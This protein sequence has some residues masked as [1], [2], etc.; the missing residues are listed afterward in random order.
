VKDFEKALNEYFESS[1]PPIHICHPRGREPKFER[2]NLI[3]KWKIK[4]GLS[5]GQIGNRL[6]MT[7]ATAQS[8]YQRA[9]HRLRDS[10]SDALRTVIN[11]PE[12]PLEI[13]WSRLGM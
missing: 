10:A 7:R 12:G 2:D 1:P 13:E 5:H 9:L 6:H 11:T 4:D 3:L 8:A